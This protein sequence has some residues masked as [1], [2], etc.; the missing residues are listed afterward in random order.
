MNKKSQITAFIVVGLALIVTIAAISY[1]KQIGEPRENYEKIYEITSSV[2]PV[3]TYVEKCL[4]DIGTI[5]IHNIS[6]HGG[7][8]NPKEF[9]YL[10]NEKI[11][12]LCIFILKIKYFLI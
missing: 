8:L 2:K 3:R 12:Y 1:I 10:N 5:T 7:S 9:Q 6:M 4:K 11:N